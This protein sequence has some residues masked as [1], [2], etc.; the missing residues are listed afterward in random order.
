[1]KVIVTGAAGFIGANLSGKLLAAGHQVIGIDNLNDYYDPDLKKDRLAQLTNHDSFIDIRAD[2]ADRELVMSLFAEHQPSHVVNLAAQPGVR[3]SLKD[4]WSYLHNNVEGFLSLLEAARA[5]P[6]EHFVYASSSSV[7]GAN[8]QMPY[9][10]HN[11]AE[12]PVSLY[13]ATKKANEMMA[14]NYAH[15]FDIPCTGLRFFTVYGPWGRPD[16]APILF[17]KAIL[18]GEPINIFNHGDMKRDFT[19][20]DDIV[21]G[22]MSVMPLPPTI[23]KAW[24]A[25]NPDPAS[26]GVA[27]YRILNIGKNRTEQLMEFIEVLEEKLG[28][29]AIRNMMPIQDGD[30]PATWADSSDLVNLTG[31]APDTSIDVGIGHFVD[32]YMDYY[33]IDKDNIG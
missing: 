2:M 21:G 27:P 16:M 22:V 13:A 33:K 8:K 11:S 9:S 17:T 7:Y 12:H 23:N 29:K 26:S 24:D 31:Y 1:M 10:E 4:P 30:V 3:H 20:V 15:L 28:R 25:Q 5:H 19:Y 32:W 14:H 18:A 6:V